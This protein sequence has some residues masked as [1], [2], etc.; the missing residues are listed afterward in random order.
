VAYSPQPIAVRHRN[1]PYPH[2]ATDIEPA[3]I[4][5]AVTVTPGAAGVPT[6]GQDGTDVFLGIRHLDYSEDDV[7]DDERKKERNEKRRKTTNIL[8]R[9]VIPNQNELLPLLSLFLF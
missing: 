5:P 3:D 1:V 8:D 9:D 4:D 2:S 6:T 7:T